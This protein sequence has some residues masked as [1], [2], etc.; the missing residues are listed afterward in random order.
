MKEYFENQ[1]MQW[2]TVVTVLLTSIMS[3]WF[4]MVVV[5]AYTVL[6]MTYKFKQS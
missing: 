1:W 6:L 5:F 4:A 2:G 3:P